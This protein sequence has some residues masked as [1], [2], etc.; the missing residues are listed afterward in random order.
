MNIVLFKTFILTK[1]DFVASAIDR[2]AIP[3]FLNTLIPTLISLSIERVP[4]TVVKFAK[5]LLDI[6]S[7][8]KRVSPKFSIIIPSTQPDIKLFTSSCAE[9]IISSN[10]RLFDGEPGKLCKWTTP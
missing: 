3:S 9:L 4:A 7:L 6:L 10:E 1:L 5:V 8:T 2:A